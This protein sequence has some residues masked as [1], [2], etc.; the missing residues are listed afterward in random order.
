MTSTLDLWFLTTGGFWAWRA[1]RACAALRRVPFLAPLGAT[2]SLER[3]TAVVAARDAT[4]A[5]TVVDGLRAQTGP[6]LQVVVVDATADGACRELAGDGVAVVPETAFGNDWLPRSHALATGVSAAEDAEWLLL[7]DEPVR[8]VTPDAI[9]RALQHARRSGAVGL[10]LVPRT[11]AG[12]L[13]PLVLSGLVDTVPAMAATNRDRATMPWLGPLFLIRADAL[14]RVGGFTAARMAPVAELMLAE[15]L[16]EIDARMRVVQAQDE[17]AL[18][19]PID[20][21]AITET[22]ERLL[23]AVGFR[24]A[25]MSVVL[26]VYALLWTTAALGPFAASPWG[27][28]AAGGLLAQIVPGLW[29]AEAHRSPRL[30]ALLLPLTLPIEVFA[31]LVTALRLSIRR[32]VTW[33]GRF[34]RI[35]ALRA[36]LRDRDS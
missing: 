11:P 16:G 12:W 24:V 4:D 23:G 22:L 31:S 10:G 35:D 32:G 14:A 9:A 1:L 21:A 18:V 28:W 2:A 8:P 33:Q 30:A 3:V 19:R 20:R 5:R 6:A 29:V 15:R 34:V 13:T 36:A 7:I 26:S 27:W 25:L 17:F